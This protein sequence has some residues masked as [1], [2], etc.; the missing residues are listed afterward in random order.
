MKSPQRERLQRLNLIVKVF[1]LLFLLSASYPT[2]VK[3][4]DVMNVTE[5]RQEITDINNGVQPDNV[6]VLTEEF[7]EV[8]EA[9]NGLNG[10]PII[11]SEIAIQKAENINGNVR[12][13]RQSAEF[14][15]FFEVSTP[16]GMLTLDGITLDEGDVN[17]SSG[18]SISVNSNS[19]LML[20]D[21][22]ITDSNANFGGGAVIIF[23]GSWTLE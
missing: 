16:A 19:G 23:G 18:G 2:L 22:I 1:L 6:I 5:L 14:F 12:I 3:A 13:Q 8:E 4:V 10:F 21:C 9:D 11:T 17:N 7:Y 20:I 15:R